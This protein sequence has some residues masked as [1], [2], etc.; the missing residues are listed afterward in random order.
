MIYENENELLTFL[1][2]LK[3]P[4]NNI[5]VLAL[6]G[7]SYTEIA[8][9]LSWTIEQ[10]Y[11]II[12]KGKVTVTSLGEECINKLIK[13]LRKKMIILPRVDCKV[14]QNSLDEIYIPY[15]KLKK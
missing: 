7:Y 1:K 3:K 10:K 11:V 9:S 4:K 13:N 8:K 6:Q 2:M 15:Y 14:P 5:S 12:I